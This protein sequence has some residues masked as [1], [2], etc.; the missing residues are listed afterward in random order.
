MNDFDVL[1][2]FTIIFLMKPEMTC[3]QCSTVVCVIE[4]GHSL[5]DLANT[6][7]AHWREKH[8]NVSSCAVCE[9]PLDPT[10]MGGYV[11]LNDSDDTHAP[12][13]PVELVPATT[14]DGSCSPEFLAALRSEIP[15]LW[16]E[17]LEGEA[18]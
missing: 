7:D 18:P 9:G 6:A 13:M 5:A 2:N 14:P 3:D 11:H 15:A 10:T 8:A 17:A 1:E 16:E 4:P 12:V